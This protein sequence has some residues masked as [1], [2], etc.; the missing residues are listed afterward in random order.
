MTSAA[1]APVSRA[2]SSGLPRSDA[3]ALERCDGRARCTAC[4]RTHAPANRM[5]PFA[6][7]WT[8]IQD[9]IAPRRP[10]D[11]PGH[12]ASPSSCRTG[13]RHVCALPLASPGA[14]NHCSRS[15][16]PHTASSIYAKVYREAAS[17]STA[18]L[19]ARRLQI[20]DTPGH[21]HWPSHSSMEPSCEHLVS[22]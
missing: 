11:P 4:T 22:W 16:A 8:C 13:S 12:H 6:M 9:Y 21:L 7:K 10:T 2:A 18:S 17:T 3:A 1:V 19:R 20:V 5:R 14:S 15:D